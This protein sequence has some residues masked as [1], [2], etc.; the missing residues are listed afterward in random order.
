MRCHRW[1]SWE[2]IPS[3]LNVGIEAAPPF[4]SAGGRPPAF[5]CN[6]RRSSP[7]RRSVR[8]CASATS[9]LSR[10]C[11]TESVARLEGVSQDL[12]G[13]TRPA[14]HIEC[15]LD[16]V[17]LCEHLTSLCDEETHIRQTGAMWLG[18]QGSD[19]SAELSRFVRRPGNHLHRGKGLPELVKGG[20]GGVA[21]NS[22]R[23]TGRGDLPGSDV[24]RFRGRQYGRVALSGSNSHR[25]LPPEAAPA[26]TSRREPLTR[27]SRR[28]AAALPRRHAIPSVTMLPEPARCRP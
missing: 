25:L 3:S 17:D 14:D 1:D 20:V 24:L 4:W 21:K 23:G 22:H 13:G 6:S 27:A 26:C 28:E 7:A 11:S 2:V 19:V 5:F 15:D 18:G 16:I 8:K 10:N 9:C 12:T